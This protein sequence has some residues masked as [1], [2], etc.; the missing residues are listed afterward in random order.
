MLD[1]VLA[2]LAFGSGKGSD[3]MP[4]TDPFGPAKRRLADHALTAVTLLCLLSGGAWLARAAAG[5]AAPP[6]VA[7]SAGPRY[8][9]KAIEEIQAGD[10]VLARDQDGREIGWR[11]V[12]ET[13]R[14]TSYHLRHLTFRAPGGGGQTLDTTDEH[15]FWSVTADAF[16][17]AGKL[18]VGDEVTGPD[19]QAQFLAAMGRT[20]HPEGV[21]VFNFRVEGYHTYYAQAADG[22][23]PPVLV[24]N[25]D[26]DVVD[27]WKAPQ[28]TRTD[29][30]DEVVNGFDPGR[31]AGDGPY[32][33][34][35]PA[36]ARV[37]Q[38]NYQNGMQHIRITR[39]DYDSL[40]SREIIQPDGYYAPGRSIH[41]LE[42]GLADFNE[43][44]RRGPA[45]S[46]V[47]E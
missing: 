35:D 21:L 9:T 8:A 5:W 16:V 7:A 34:L 40:V 46:Y 6:A 1:D 12:E 36:V 17:N 18:Q 24:H 25:A 30:L 29:A 22:R 15:P 38:Q 20:E 23:G 4:A 47:P 31:Y 45:N 10:E 19:G 28:R 3:A 41:I 44:I 2:E 42:G 14:R 27:V 33:A 26:Y 39:S 37:W 32:F 43:A 13:F 11:R